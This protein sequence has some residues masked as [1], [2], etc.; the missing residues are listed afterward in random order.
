MACFSRRNSRVVKRR[1]RGAARG[2]LRRLSR[3]RASLERSK[4]RDILQGFPVSKTTHV[5]EDLYELYLS[6][7]LAFWVC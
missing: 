5:F 1:E 2:V 4:E 6:I 7:V 3:E